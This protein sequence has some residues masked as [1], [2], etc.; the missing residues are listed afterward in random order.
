MQLDFAIAR[1]WSP[2]L[3]SIP[4]SPDEML[5]RYDFLLGDLLLKVSG[6]DLSTA[7]SSIP[8]LDVAAGLRSVVDRLAAGSSQ[9]SFDFTEGGTIDFS[10]DG[11]GRVCVSAFYA[12]G[13]G[14]AT[15]TELRVAV[16]DFVERVLDA[17]FAIHPSLV[18]NESL[19]K[20]YPSQ[21]FRSSH[22]IPMS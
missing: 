10:A 8:L 21:R 12:H 9:V 18:G 19:P 17:A 13:Q 2:A 14:C 5:L 7:S 1:T 16:L 3:T 22:G 6:T 15:L 4:G 20:W 11:H